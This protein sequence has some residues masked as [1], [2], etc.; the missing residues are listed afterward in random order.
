VVT[1]RWLG[2]PWRVAAR[3]V[4]GIGLATIGWRQPRQLLGVV[5]AAVLVAVVQAMRQ[6][7]VAAALAVSSVALCAIVCPLAD[8][9]VCRRS[10]DAADRYAAVCGVGP[11]LASALR[12]THSGL[13]SREVNWT[14]RMLSRHPS[15]DRRLEVLD[16]IVIRPRRASTRTVGERECLARDGHRCP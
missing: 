5:V 4:T 9:A 6:G 8:A 2:A 12:S 11:Q 15:V 3:L 1:A 16:A 13:S 7:D 14:R 10:E